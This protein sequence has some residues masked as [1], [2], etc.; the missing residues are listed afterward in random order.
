MT[1]PL[2]VTSQP[3]FDAADII[4]K[5]LQ[6]RNPVAR[7]CIRRIVDLI[8][9]KRSFALT[10][11]ALRIESEGGMPT[12]DGHRQRTT[13]GIFFYLFSQSVTPAQQREV[14]LLQARLQQEFD[15]RK[16]IRGSKKQ[17]GRLGSLS[18]PVDLHTSREMVAQL[19]ENAGKADAV[20][21]KIV[22]RP[23]KAQQQDGLVVFQMR[24]EGER[25]KLPKVLPPL[26]D[27]PQT[28]VIYLSAKI[29]VKL[30]PLLE[31]PEQKLFIEGH[32]AFDPQLKKPVIYAL[33]A[34]PREKSESQTDKPAP[35][36]KPLTVSADED[37]TTT[38]IPFPAAIPPLPPINIDIDDDDT[39][40]TPIPIQIP[41]M[42]D[43]ASASPDVR[44]TQDAPASA[45]SAQEIEARL[46]QLRD[47]E[48]NARKRVEA[49][50]A[51]PFS[52]RRELSQAVMDLEAIQT[53]IKAL[54]AALNAL[55][56]ARS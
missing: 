21:V 2:T 7:E 45:L 49:I 16:R 9:V 12:Q 55:V 6:E 20:K 27:A 52:Q 17:Y 1:K 47:D 35:R 23:G 4:A 3:H 8:G 26:P 46:T 32:L 31:Q 53:R 10:D 14:H 54:D 44:D 19:G 36:P 33:G 43:S 41:P 22:G 28:Y 18:V 5:R 24:D 29:W 30:V 25:P 38:P 56:N 15:I 13:G 48:R 51:L 11:E 37:T 34:Y 39:A 42:G 40:T 50:K